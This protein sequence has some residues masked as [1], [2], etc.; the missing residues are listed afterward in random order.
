ME[1]DDRVRFEQY[2]FPVLPGLIYEKDGNEHIGELLF[3]DDG[4]D[5]FQ[6]YF[7]SGMACL[8]LR[9]WEKDPEK[10]TWREY[11][12][13]NLKLH[14]CGPARGDGKV[15]FVGYFHAELT[16]DVGRVHILPGQLSLA[17]PAGQLDGLRC[18][19][20]LCE[21]MD[22]LRVEP[23]AVRNAAGA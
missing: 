3:I 21:L 9:A 17:R 14:L 8:D 10:V 7:E 2:S 16:D 22:G 1:R 4:R 6:I 12:F 13:G 15:A 18:I 23:D 19:T 5:R 20:A 11:S